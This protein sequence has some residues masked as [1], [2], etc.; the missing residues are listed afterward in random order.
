M[1]R[2]RSGR[3]EALVQ[4]SYSFNYYYT[5]LSLLAKAMFKWENLPNGIPERFIEK[6]LFSSGNLAFFKDEKLGYM[7]TKCTV[8]SSLNFYDE[9][10][11]YNCYGNGY[12]S[13]TVKAEN[14]V[15]IRNNQDSIPTNFIVKRFAEKLY[16]LDRTQDVNIQLQKYP[17]LIECD[18]QQK[19]TI[20]NLLLDYE[21]N[22][23][24]ILVNKNIDLSKFN[25][26]SF[27]VPFIADQMQKH[28][29]DVI[30]EF[31]TCL[32]INN[33][34]TAKKERLVTDEVNAN[35]QHLLLQNDI[36]LLERLNA[37]RKINEMFGLE[38][39]VSRREGEEIW[40]NIQLN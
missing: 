23:P 20:E 12:Y 15:I 14:L 9:P 30:N 37:V 4:N 8:E 35:N 11:A 16:N 39:E 26:L 17:A 7:V 32:G 5:M 31:L 6:T 22:I 13:N 38:I 21:G 40:Q 29:L 10:I 3:Q 36:F 27:N 33:A 1:G 34:N 2:K 18:E 24:L 28:K 19:L 25:T